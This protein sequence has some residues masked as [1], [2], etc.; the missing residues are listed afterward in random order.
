MKPKRVHK[1][2]RVEVALWE[3][4]NKNG[5]PFTTFAVG[6]RYKDESGSWKSSN[7]FS[8]DAMI[9][10]NEILNYEIRRAQSEAQ[11]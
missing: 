11:Q 5:E 1:I 4:E 3:N 8:L 2:G 6:S 10:L 7:S 9:V